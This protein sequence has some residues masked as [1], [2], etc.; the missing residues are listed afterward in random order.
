MPGEMQSYRS[1]QID[2]IEVTTYRALQGIE[3]FSLSEHRHIAPAG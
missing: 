2:V 1:W 3:R